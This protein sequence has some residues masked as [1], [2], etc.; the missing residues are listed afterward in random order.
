M[1]EKPTNVE[2]YKKWFRDKHAMNV[3]QM[4]IHYESVTNKILVDVQNSKA[5]NTL[6]DNVDTIDQTYWM[7]TGCRLIADEYR[8]QLQHKSFDSFFEKTFRKNVITNQEWPLPP[9]GGWFLPENWHIRINDVVRTLLVVRY[10]DGVLFAADE[11]EALMQSINLCCMRSLE[12]RAEG[13]YA[14]HLDIRVPVEIP[15]IDWDTDDI[16]VSVELQI[17]TQ[18]QEVIR[19]LLHA[20]YEERRVVSPVEEGAPWQWDYTKVEF[21]T[22]YLGHVLH[23]ID[24]MI[25]DIREKIDRRKR[26]IE[27]RMD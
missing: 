27:R 22:N 1:E 12:A 14:A 19:Q 21:S 11:I 9:Q 3:S 15:R 13:Y 25:V 23:Y 26:N 17:T 20:Y 10:L 8:L 6:L 16:E 7:K 18:A 5:W 4:K 24:G 2:E